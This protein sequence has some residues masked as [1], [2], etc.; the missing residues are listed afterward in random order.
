M[1]I[2][3]DRK[4]ISIE[5][6]RGCLVIRVPIRMVFEQLPAEGFGVANTHITKREEQCLRGVLQSKQNKE[7]ATDMNVS[8]R[9]VKFHVSALLAKNNIHSRHE[10][11]KIYSECVRGNGNG[12]GG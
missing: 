3:H 2:E 1:K 7:I 6:E 11:Q 10:L 9:T 4:R 5:I 12:V 8:V